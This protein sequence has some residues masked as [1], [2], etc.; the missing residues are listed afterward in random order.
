RFDLFP[1]VMYES[2]V[3]F[4]DD[5][6]NTRTSVISRS[7]MPAALSAPIF[8]AAF[9]AGSYFSWMD[10]TCAFCDSVSGRA[11]HVAGLARPYVWIDWALI[12]LVLMP[13]LMQQAITANRI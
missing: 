6:S 11:V 3:T 12:E 9:I 10:F 2:N 13:V 8:R 1:P 4:C 5:V 7:L